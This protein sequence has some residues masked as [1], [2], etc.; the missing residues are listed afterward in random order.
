[1]VFVDEGDAPMRDA[2]P[3]RVLGDVVVVGSDLSHTCDEVPRGDDDGFFGEPGENA[4]DAFQE[5][6]V[7]FAPAHVIVEMDAGLF[8]VALIA[9]VGFAFVLHA[10]GEVDL[11]GSLPA[12][13]ATGGISLETG[14]VDSLTEEVDDSVTLG[15]AVVVD[16]WI[17]SIRHV[18][19]PDKNDSFEVEFLLVADELAILNKAR[20]HFAV[21]LG[22][23]KFLKRFSVMRSSHHL[24]IARE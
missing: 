21:L 9:E 5:G 20:K 13:A 7:V 24:A 19:V 14:E 3:I 12:A 16:A 2:V 17:K 1:M 23:G 18:S 22:T 11:V 15:V 8:G 10:E 6:V 4:A